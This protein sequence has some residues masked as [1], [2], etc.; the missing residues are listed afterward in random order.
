MP[1]GISQLDAM[2]ATRPLTL[3]LGLWAGLRGFFEN[4]FKRR[5]E[6]FANSPPAIAGSKQ[7]SRSLDESTAQRRRAQSRAAA[8]I[9]KINHTAK[10]VQACPY[11]QKSSG[12]TPR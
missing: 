1:T 6:L 12:A 5:C 2:S 3:R 11:R 10:G 9:W 4:V 7:A 8:T